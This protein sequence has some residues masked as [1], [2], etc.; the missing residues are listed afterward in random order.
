MSK[1]STSN[2][3]FISYTGEILEHEIISCW[4]QF[5][6]KKTIAQEQKSANYNAVTRFPSHVSCCISCYDFRLTK[7]LVWQ[8]ESEN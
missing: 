5:T 8:R 1:S 2:K 4:L 3:T 7:T 6:A